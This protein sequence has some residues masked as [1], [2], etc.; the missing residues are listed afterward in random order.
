MSP[1]RPGDDGIG[2]A[3]RHGHGRIHARHFF[4][5]QHVGDGVQPGAAPLFRNQ[6]PAAAEF[7]EAPDLRAGEFFLAVVAADD[8]AH[9]RFHEPPDTFSH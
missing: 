4:E 2:H 6:H 1:E 8:R 7:S 5:H 3:Q 9:F